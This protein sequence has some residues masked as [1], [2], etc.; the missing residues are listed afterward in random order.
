[1]KRPKK[2]ASDPGFTLIEV[3]LAILIFGILSSAVLTSFNALFSSSQRLERDIALMEMGHKCLNR[4]ISDISAA[5]ISLP[6]AYAIPQV[7]AIDS[8]KKADP[9]R[10]VG[11][12]GGAGFPQLRFASRAHLPID[13][14]SGKGVARIVYY[15][16]ENQ[17]QGFSLKRADDLNLKASFEENRNDPVLCE[18]VISLAFAYHWQEDDVKEAW[19]SEAREYG[20]ATPQAISIRLEIGDAQKKKVL[21]TTAIPPAYR[22]KK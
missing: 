6:P 9:F 21:K 11:D 14:N 20:Y 15:V 18:E 22:G 5:H 19:D 8:E 12:A 10:I 13:G 16:A 3:V 4:M 2:E 7:S 1:M 17:D